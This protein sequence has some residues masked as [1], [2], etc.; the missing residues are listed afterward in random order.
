M[1]T[2]NN[3]K[4]GD[5]VTF[6][7]PNGRGR[8]GVEYKQASGR[9]VMS[10]EAHVVLNC[11]GRFGTPGVCDA[12]NYVKHS[13]PK[14]AAPKPTHKQFVVASRSSN[15][16]AFGHHGLILMARDGEAWE[17]SRYLYAEDFAKTAK[18]CVL[19]F[20]IVNGRPQFTGC[21]IPR[22][23]PDAPANVVAE[24]WGGVQ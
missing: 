1:N 7:R 20:P 2:F 22:R 15:V 4:P 14:P 6:L 11:G 16:N 10:F 12:G 9:C 19:T 18:G 17:V 3:I 13:S 8:N 23:L 21:E 24:V 5:R